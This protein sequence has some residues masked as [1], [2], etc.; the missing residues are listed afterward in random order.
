MIE[1][2]FPFVSGTQHPELTLEEVGPKVA[3][4][5]PWWTKTL[6]DLQ[7][8]CQEVQFSRF[9]RGFRLAAVHVDRE[10]PRTD[11]DYSP[12][13]VNPQKG[14]WRLTTAQF[15]VETVPSLRAWILFFVLVFQHILFGVVPLW[16]C[17]WIVVL[18]ILYWLAKPPDLEDVKQA[19]LSIQEVLKNQR[20]VPTNL[21]LFPKEPKKDA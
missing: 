9:L 19:Q 12:A 16:L 11:Q 20:V 17:V 10:P 6:D 21:A 4:D 15:H 2:D 5:V 8:P 14:E 3:R 7:K 13:A 18:F 1:S